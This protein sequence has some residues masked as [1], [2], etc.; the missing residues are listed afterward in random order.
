MNT[1]RFVRSLCAIGLLSGL[2]VSCLPGGLLFGDA[3]ASGQPSGGTVQI[4][5]TP[6]STGNGG[7]KVLVT[8]AIGDYG[9]G[10]KVNSSGKPNSKGLYNN[11]RL[12]KGTIL[13][14]LTQ[15]TAAENNINP[16]INASNCSTSATFSA[17]VQIV[18]GTKA[19]AGITGTANFTAQLALILPRTKSG[20]CN[21]NG[22]PIAQY[23][24]VAG[25]GT[26]SF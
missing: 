5:V 8:G 24:S 7:G 23:G 19:Y 18:S 16:S 10:Q 20:S 2:G 6:S 25:T 9:P 14:N 21:T 17:P 1:P 11:L 26:V 4:W 15:F 13:V 12:K 22:N 3:V